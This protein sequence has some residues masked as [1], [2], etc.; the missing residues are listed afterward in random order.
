MRSNT[1]EPSKHLV[2]LTMNGFGNSNGNAPLELCNGVV[3][4]CGMS[5]NGVA[6]HRR[7]EPPYGPGSH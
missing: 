7:I 1:E 2:D 3:E 5:A 4:R 6:T